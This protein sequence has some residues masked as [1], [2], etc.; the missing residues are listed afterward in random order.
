MNLGDNEI[1][2][3]YIGDSAIDEAYLG[4]ELVFSSG[5]FV[6]L[7]ISPKTIGFSPIT[8]TKTIKVKASEA[9]SMTLPAWV[10]ASQTTGDTGDTII[11]LTTTAQAAATADT[12]T[13]TSANFS[14]SANVSY[15]ISYWTFVTSSS[16]D[17]SLPLTKLRF[18]MN[19]IPAGT[20]RLG[21]TEG[22]VSE[23][24]NKNTDGNY[25]GTYDQPTYGYPRY[26][27]FNMVYNGGQYLNEFNH[28]ITTETKINTLPEIESGVFEWTFGGVLYW[29]GMEQ[30]TSPVYTNGNLIE[31]FVDFSAV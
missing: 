18:H 8:L 16:F 4:E 30:L 27:K 22:A 26:H 24:P 20:P 29:S 23:L 6:G 19:N 13:V 25:S 12:I 5:P 14:A 9:W 15:T 11:T 10:S 7:R 1:L 21:A 17:R 28:T 31:V 3:C 2:E